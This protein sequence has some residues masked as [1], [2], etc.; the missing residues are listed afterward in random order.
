MRG[1]SKE[2]SRTTRRWA[3]R[4]MRTARVCGSGA[5]WLTPLMRR[6]LKSEPTQGAWP[7]PLPVAAA[8]TRV[9]S[10]QPREKPSTR[11]VRAAVARKAETPGGTMN[12]LRT[13]ARQLSAS[14]S[15]ASSN[16]SR[17]RTS[18]SGE[19]SRRGRWSSTARIRSSSRAAAAQAAQASRWAAAPPPPPAPRP[20]STQKRRLSSPV[21]VL[22]REAPALARAQAGEG[23]L[24]APLRLPA[25]GGAL[26]VERG[27]LFR[28]GVEELGLA[29]LA[30]R[31]LHF[32]AG[33]GAPQMIEADDQHHPVHPGRKARL[34]PEAAERAVN[35]QERLLVNV[36][37]LVFRAHHLESQPEHTPL[38]QPH[39]LLESGPIAPL[40]LADQSPF[41]QRVERR[42]DSGHS[43]DQL[44]AAF[45]RARGGFLVNRLDASRSQR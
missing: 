28:Q 27:A 8:G 13:R 26:G 37:R 16:A 38:V 11:M 34:E 5:T 36:L 10:V 39:Q 43:V 41:L 17:L 12:Q 22:Q 14:R 44:Q 4:V 18:S 42:R 23:G 40:S 35:L 1:S 25:L 6:L 7:E 15:S 24:D 3:S 45:H 30:F 32:A 20:P 9:R 19:G 31:R 2:P 21:V 33:A 29:G